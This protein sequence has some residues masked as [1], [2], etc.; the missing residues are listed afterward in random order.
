M[1]VLA[2]IVL[3]TNLAYS[4]AYDTETRCPCW[5]AYDLEPGE[6]VKAK[7]ADIPFRADPRVPESDNAADYSGS[8][9]DRGHMAPAADFN[10]DAAALKETYY[11]SNIAPQVPA[12]N[13][14]A[15]LD[16]ENEIR[17]LAASG[18]VHVVVWPEYHS[19]QTNRIGRVRVPIAF[20]KTAY[21][22]FGLRC[23][24]YNN[25]EWKSGFLGECETGKE[26]EPCTS[27]WLRWL[28]PW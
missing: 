27:S 6:V 5:V 17:R 2:S 20:N 11:Y 10:F 16:A 24:R 1:N 8:G 19:D 4:V 28:W 22:W 18:T 3:L 14:G 13:R 9:Y 26:A 21:G 7:R 23:W 15:W 25:V 12:L